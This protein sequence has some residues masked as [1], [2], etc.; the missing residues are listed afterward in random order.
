[1]LSL[2]RLFYPK[3]AGLITL[4]CIFWPVFS[5]QAARCNTSPVFAFSQA[6]YLQ[7]YARADELLARLPLER[8][9]ELATFLTQVMAWKRAYDTDERP[10]QLE[11]LEAIDKQI[12]KLDKAL[13]T[14][15]P[16]RPKLELI[17][18]NIKIHAARMNLVTGHVFKAARLAK[19]GNQLLREVLKQNPDQVDAYLAAGL[20]QYYIGSDDSG[21]F[22]IKQL[23]S[24]Q[25]DKQ[26]GRDLI[27]KAMQLSPDYAFEAARSLKM[28]LSWNK[29]ELCHYPT[30]ISNN[31][32]VS[33]LPT[34]VLQLEISA[35]L[36]CGR[37]QHA[38]SLIGRL[39]AQIER[40]QS[41]D[42]KDQ[43]RWLDDAS[44][45]ALSQQ[46]EVDLLAQMA[47]K[48]DLQSNPSR[49]ERVEFSLAKA[50]DVKRERVRAKHLYQ[51]LLESKTEAAYK[52]LSQHYLTQAYRGT[53]STDQRRK[54][55]FAC[56][57]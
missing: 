19:Q 4:L 5:V 20:Y 28:E 38:N 8:S 53:A 32:P 21:F 23:F 43:K 18:G 7:Q 55:V 37:T 33:K 40:L 42:S 17:T 56:G 13:E 41:N 24:L 44:L 15:L 46:G 52:S 14:E 51:K 45:Y 9:P 27:E 29:N 30:L 36:F 26:Q 25:G 35:D 54:Q 6:L 12:D 1:M 11:A 3:P 2:L 16:T 57:D 50:L 31:L 39:R 49:K 48:S 34:E 47:D 22:W 10:A